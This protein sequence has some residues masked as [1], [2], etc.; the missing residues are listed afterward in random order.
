MAQHVSI[1]RAEESSAL[2]AHEDSHALTEPD[3]Q[4]RTA[5]KM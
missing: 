3:V 4:N 5:M 2:I 1:L